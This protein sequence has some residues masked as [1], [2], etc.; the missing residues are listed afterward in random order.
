MTEAG[1]TYKIYIA[2]ASSKG[3]SKS[4]LSEHNFYNENQ[5]SFPGITKFG[6]ALIDDAL[7]NEKCK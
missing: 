4:F 5:Y 6:Q 7:D 1:K 3:I 2:K